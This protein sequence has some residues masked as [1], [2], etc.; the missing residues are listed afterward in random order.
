M[1][2]KLKNLLLIFLFTLI[3][4]ILLSS[5]SFARPIPT[6]ITTLVL[7]GDARNLIQES[8]FRIP[9][10]LIHG[11][12]GTEPKNYTYEHGNSIENP[13]QTINGS[14]SNERAYFENFMNYFYLK[15]LH[16]KYTLFRFHYR[17]EI[18]PVRD[19][20]RGLRQWIDELTVQGL[21]P[22]QPIVIIAHSMGGL[23]AKSY[24][25]EQFHTVGRYACQPGGERV[26]R[27]ITL[28]TPHHG[29]PAA[30]DEARIEGRTDKTLPAILKILDLLLWLKTP[31]ACKA[32][33]Q[34]SGLD[35]MEQDLISRF[36]NMISIWQACQYVQVSESNRT[37]FRYDNYD[38]RSPAYEYGEERNE[39]LKRLNDSFHYENKLIAYYGVLDPA[40][41]LY[42]RLIQMKPINVLATFLHYY[43]NGVI[44]ADDPYNPYGRE[45]PFFGNTKGAQHSQ[46]LFA[47]AMIKVLFDLENDGMVPLESVTFRGERLWEKPV[48]LAGYDHLD[49]KDDKLV[50]QDGK[51]RAPKLFRMLKDD[52]EE[53]FETYKPEKPIEDMENI[54]I[55]RF[56]K[57]D[58]K[59]QFKEKQELAVIKAG[60]L[61]FIHYVDWAE[62]AEVGEDYS[63]WLR[64][65]RRKVHG[66]TVTIE[67][68][69]QIRTSAMFSHGRW[70]TEEKINITLDLSVL[71]DVETIDD[72]NMFR[73]IMDQLRDQ[74]PC[75]MIVIG[76][77]SFQ[78]MLFILTAEGLGSAP[79][80][81]EAFEGMVVGAHLMTTLKT[82]LTK[83]M[84]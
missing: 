21:M 34:E 33:L 71:Q 66:N 51:P 48:F 36:I 75:G 70:L 26:A 57:F 76:D 72:Y 78:T 18:L 17:S 2:R 47:G 56:M 46:L 52:L 60:L 74:K 13:I 22:E 9:L 53:L 41:K 30:N 10:I 24:M 14:T 58:V 12:H 44:P 82:L 35:L 5:I 28:A 20:A 27:L 50:E 63:L 55:G 23:V 32:T 4:M 39:W 73:L 37:D 38:H 84:P 77:E 67:L 8:S 54:T 79:T 64:G 7:D 25:Q 45:L 62:L 3:L 19:I 16:R 83:G 11:I 42:Q 80:P 69:L 29:S 1:K 15:G 40:D 59:T 49:M 68:T 65:Y 6:T 31:D 61:A 43:V 81:Y